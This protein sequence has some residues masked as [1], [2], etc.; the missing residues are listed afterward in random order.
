MVS[1]I[2]IRSSCTR[3]LSSLSLGRYKPLSTHSTR[4]LLRHNSWHRSCCPVRYEV[5]IDDDS[6]DL[7]LRELPEYSLIVGSGKCLVAIWL[8]VTPLEGCLN[9][10]NSRRTGETR[11]AQAITKVVFWSVHEMTS[12]IIANT[13]MSPIPYTSWIR[14]LRQRLQRTQI[15]NPNVPLLQ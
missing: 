9:V 2:H 13:S 1:E 14:L 10:K 6:C 11:E 4:P 7:I 3:L 8:E 12:A 15:K 5:M